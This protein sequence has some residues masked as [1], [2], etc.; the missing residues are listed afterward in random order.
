MCDDIGFIDEFTPPGRVFHVRI[1][2]D[3]N[4]IVYYRFDGF[5]AQGADGSLELELVDPY[6][7]DVILDPDTDQPWTTEAWNDR[8]AKMV[9][10]CDDP[11]E[12]MF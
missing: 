6:T 9:L 3:P 8:A 10:S 11:I 4:E 12:E 2:H 1:G 7:D 5:G